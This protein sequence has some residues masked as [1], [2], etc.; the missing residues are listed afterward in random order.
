[1]YS[2]PG[3][4]LTFG[5]SSTS[6]LMDAKRIQQVLSNQERQVAVSACG[7]TCPWLQMALLRICW[8][9]PLGHYWVAGPL[10]GSQPGE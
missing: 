3:C 10:Q 5:W 8:Q 6:C 1:M 2:I 4:L 7:W 9:L